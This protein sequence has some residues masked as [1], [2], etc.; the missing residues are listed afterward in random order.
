MT[1]RKLEPITDEH[2]MEVNMAFN[3]LVKSYQGWKKYRQTCN[4]LGRLSEREL[5]DLGLAPGDIREVA[6]RSA[7][8]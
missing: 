8:L 2:Q 4:E 3:G 7:G 1:G 5:D 6:R